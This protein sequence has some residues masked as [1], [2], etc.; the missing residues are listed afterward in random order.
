MD[1]TVQD[2]QRRL[3][4]LGY[5]PGEADGIS[6]PITD[7][8]VR[9]FQIAEGLAVDGVAGPKTLARPRERKSSPRYLAIPPPQ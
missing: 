4:A 2:L 9:L 1:T 3:T 6:G 8:A 5:N 7:R